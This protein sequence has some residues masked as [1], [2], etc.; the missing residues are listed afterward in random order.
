MNLWIPQAP[1]ERRLG[2]PL[3]RVV[4]WGMIGWLLVFSMRTIQGPVAACTRGWSDP[5][6]PITATGQKRTGIGEVT[7]FLT[8]TCNDGS[9]EVFL[10]PLG[11]YSL[12]PMQT[13]KLC[14]GF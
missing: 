8:D 5:Q 13:L 7:V 11:W 3:G 4:R 10:T 12:G 2:G 6:G 14:G 1:R 9:C